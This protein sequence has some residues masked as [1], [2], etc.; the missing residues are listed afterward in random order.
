MG[1]TDSTGRVSSWL[2]ITLKAAQ[3]PVPTHQ[4]V[5]RECLCLGVTEILTSLYKYVQLSP[6]LPPILRNVLTCASVQYS[7]I[8]PWQGSHHDQPGVPRTRLIPCSPLML[9]FTLGLFAVGLDELV[10]YFY[11]YSIP[12]HSILQP[13][14]M[15]SRRGRTRTARLHFGIY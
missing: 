8:P 13:L 15:A 2:L 4:G 11:F 10:N 3:T 14:P 5:L 1:T 7:I 9:G 6:H 12:F